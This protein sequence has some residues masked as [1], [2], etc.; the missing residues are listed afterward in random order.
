MK[1]KLLLLLIT[2]LFALPILAQPSGWSYRF[3]ITITENSGT[4][5]YNYQVRVVL[6]TQALVSAGQMDATGNDIRFG[7]TCSGSSFY[8]YWIESGMNTASTVIW[9]QVDTLLASSTRTIY[10]YHGNAAATSVSTLSVFS[11]PHSATDSV[12]GG[13]A[14][15]V[16]DSQRGFRFSPNED[17]LVTQFGKNEPNGSTRYITLFDYSSQAILEQTQVSGPAAAYSYGAISN[18]IWLNAGTQYLLILFQGSSDGYYFGAAPQMGQHLTYYDMRYCNGCTEN[19]FPTSSLGGMHY[20]YVDMLYYT[21]QSASVDPT[22]VPGSGTLAV[23]TTGT[24][25]CEGS[26]VTLSA[27]TTGGTMPYSYQ[28][29]PAASLSSSTAANPVASPTTSTTYSVTVTDGGGCSVSSTLTVNVLSLPAVN[30]G[31]DITVCSGNPVMLDAGTSGI[32][33]AWSNAATTQTINVTSAGTYSVMVTD[34]N[35]CSNSDTI[36]VAFNPLPSV[37]LGADVT[38]CGGSVLLDAGNAG[39]T[40][41]WQDA[42]SAQTLTA[43]STGTYY[44]VVT[45]ANGCEGS[46]TVEV[47]INALP[48]VNLGADVSVCAGDTVMLDAGTAGATYAWSNT[49]TTQTINVVTT[50]IYSVLVTDANACSSSDT[51]SVTFNS[52][53]VV[54]LGADVTQCGGSVTLDAGNAGANYQWQDASTAQT[55]NVVATGTYY[56]VVTDPNTGCAGSDTVDVTINPV[57]SVT[58]AMANDTVCINWS[59]FNLSGG[60]PAGGSY[61]GTGVNAGMF[62]PS[63]A[64]AGTHTITYTLTDNNGCTGGATQDVVVDVCTGIEEYG[65]SVVNIYPNPST[66]MVM[67]TLAVNDARLQVFSPDMKKVIDR[68]VQG[69]GGKNQVALDLSGYAKGIYFV[70]IQSATETVTNKLIIE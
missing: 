40:Y 32:S 14:G 21:K 49:A 11:G 51:V 54:S 62:D 50:G 17:I 37:N 46:D 10:M 1:R 59:A 57:P 13:S 12:T 3:P 18:P 36:A 35:S 5:L 6:N 27:S 19:T 8:P 24:S 26:S 47:T 2:G 31:P 60:S 22:V 4:N 25:L 9:V 63:A 45:D 39:A 20:G 30:L 66:G 52:N 65:S 44:V 42:S 23:S 56:V 48:S 7:G 41:Q 15:G 67:I 29:S 55:L 16:T 70:V 28:W 43:A 58:L 34:G 53:P 61:T 68:N 38:Q 69:A 33:Y 64:G